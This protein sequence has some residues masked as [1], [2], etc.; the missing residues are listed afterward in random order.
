MVVILFNIYNI[1]SYLY[2]KSYQM[3]GW[4]VGWL[5]FYV[6]VGYL[7]PNSVYSYIKPKILE[8]I[9]CR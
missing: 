9:L 8:W 3:V 4:L 2:Y 7:I 5:D 1:Y 6:I